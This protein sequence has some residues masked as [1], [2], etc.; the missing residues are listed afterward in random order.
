MQYMEGNTIKIVFVPKRD[1]VNV[2][3]FVSVPEL[4]YLLHKKIVSS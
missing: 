2:D 1:L 3:L 4:T